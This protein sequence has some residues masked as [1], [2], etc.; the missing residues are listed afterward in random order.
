MCGNRRKVATQGR[1]RLGSV[2]FLPA[3]P[4][5]T[6]SQPQTALQLSH[7]NQLPNNKKLNT[8]YQLRFGRIETLR[9]SAELA[10]CT[11]FFSFRAVHRQQSLEPHFHTLH[12]TERA[13]T[14]QQVRH[15]PGCSPSSPAMFL[16]VTC[17]CR[18]G[19]L[20]PLLAAVTAEPPTPAYTALQHR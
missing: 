1:T 19:L 9:S 11:H 10:F 20:A 7:A 15:T 18:V 13:T 5:P 12:G 4:P 8:S 16:L 6:S 14:C 17:L 2:P 3:D